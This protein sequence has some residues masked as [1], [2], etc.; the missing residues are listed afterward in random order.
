MSV[1]R[2]A[3]V[4][5]G[6]PRHTKQHTPNESF[7]RSHGIPFI[8]K[9]HSRNIQNTIFCIIIP[10]SVRSY[11]I[12]LNEKYHTIADLKTPVEYFAV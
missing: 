2:A 1:T 12:V 7:A 9:N 10:L 11:I 4:C 3:F 5:P 8:V 6:W